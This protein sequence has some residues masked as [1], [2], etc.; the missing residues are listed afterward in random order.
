MI[1]CLLRLS[2]T[3]SNPAPHDQFKSRAGADSIEQYEEWDT[4]HVREKFA[5]VDTKIAE[6]LGKAMAQRRQ[7]FKYREKHINRLAEGLDGDGLGVEADL[8]EDGERA[9]TVASSLPDHLKESRGGTEST[10]NEFAGW[11]DS[12]SEMSGTSYAPSTI[13][14]DQLRVPPMPKEYI[15]GPFK[16]PFC[17]MIVSIDT[18]HAWKYS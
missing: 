18:R 10:M 14:S 17:H 12:R 3:L 2:V 9:T 5:D 13:N 6:R 8:G 7:Y 15:D 16:C 11:D 4:K 1:D